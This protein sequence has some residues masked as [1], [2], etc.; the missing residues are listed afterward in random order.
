MRTDRFPE[1]PF[2]PV[3][4]TGE[5][6]EAVLRLLAE[7]SEGVERMLPE[8]EPWARPPPSPEVRGRE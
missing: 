8:L 5:A 2:Q 4:V 7:S 1:L 6:A 3:P